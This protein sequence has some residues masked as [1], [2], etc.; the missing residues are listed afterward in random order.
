MEE[1]ITVRFDNFQGTGAIYI[2]FT[3]RAL[4]YVYSGL[5]LYHLYGN[6]KSAWNIERYYRLGRSMVYGI[7]HCVVAQYITCVRP[8]K[9]FVSGISL[10]DLEYTYSFRNI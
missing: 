7:S 2:L 9:F 6:L 1:A 3:Q 10:M 8:G 5:E 4:V